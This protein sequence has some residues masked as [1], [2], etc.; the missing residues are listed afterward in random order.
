MAPQQHNMAAAA[1][2]GHSNPL[3]EAGPKASGDISGGKKERH[4][5]ESFGKTL[6]TPKHAQGGF[7]SMPFDLFPYHP[8][9]EAEEVKSWSGFLL[10]VLSVLIFLAFSG[11]TIELYATQTF[12]KSLATVALNPNIAVTPQSNPILFQAGMLMRF[13]GNGSSFSDP[14]IFKYA[15]SARA[16]LSQDSNGKSSRL[17]TP[18]NLTECTFTTAQG[19]SGGDGICFDYDSSRNLA[20]LQGDYGFPFYRYIQFDILSCVNGT[21]PGVVCKP[22]AF[23]DNFIY[24]QMEAVFITSHDVWVDDNVHIGEPMKTR[25]LY[26][27]SR[28]DFPTGIAQKVD[29]YSQVRVL[30]KNSP[31]VSWSA[32]QTTYQDITVGQ[33][34]TNVLSTRSAP[35]DS[36]LKMYLRLSADVV[37]S[38]L[39]CQQDFLSML[40]SL[41]SIYALLML[42]FGKPGEL[43][44]GWLYAR[45]N[46]PTREGSAGSVE[47]DPEL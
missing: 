16:V 7:F 22:Q 41:G 18:L 11:Y 24:N 25:H 17:N 6:A 20:I 29:V 32:L 34:L 2:Q 44:N 3:W 15:F 35:T 28:Y 23:I 10:T 30:T 33:L 40:S 1:P 36:Y 46:R 19:N 27:S 5:W 4:T 12:Q 14:T 9:E 37:T 8:A 21:V 42:V 13:I 26:S 45:A 38:E 39:S 31:V 43:L 47:R